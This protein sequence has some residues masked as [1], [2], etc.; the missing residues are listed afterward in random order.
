MSARPL[1]ALALV[2]ALTASA[3]D[4]GLTAY[5][6]KQGGKR[7]IYS[8]YVLEHV[9][10]SAG[11]YVWAHYDGRDYVIRDSAVIESFAKILA[12]V[13]SYESEKSEIRRKLAAAKTEREKRS[14]RQEMQR[15]DDQKREKQSAAEIE[16][17]RIVDRAI[18][19]GV[20]V[21]A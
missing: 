14:L 20:A 9:F 6:V 18:R 5:I 8:Y 21:K 10:E 16:L 17:A 4:T 15:M 2:A 3:A 13:P 1:L 12:A 7:E 11:D 19:S